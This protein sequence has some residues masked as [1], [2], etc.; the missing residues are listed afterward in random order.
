MQKRG[1]RQRGLF[2][3]RI[4]KCDCNPRLPAEHFRV[5]KEGKNK[6]RWFYTCQ[7]QEPKRC[8]FFLWDEDAKPREAAT[9]MS[10]STSEVQQNRHHDQDGWNAGRQAV[11]GNGVFSN[12]NAKRER[13]GHRSPTLSPYDTLQSGSKRSLASTG[14]DNSDD[15][16]G[17]N[18]DDDA[19]LR[20]ADS[21]ETPHKAQKIGVYATPATGKKSARKLPWL[22]Q[23]ATPSSTIKST[24]GYPATPSNSS[25]SR[26][27]GGNA[28]TTNTISGPPD[29]PTPHARFIDALAN[30]A[31]CASSLTQEVL[32][33][34]S[35]VSLP[36]EKLSTL[37]TILSRHDLKAQ[38]VAKGREIS[39][40]ALKAKEAKIVEL[41]SKIVRLE[42]E[43]EVDRG[44]IQKLRWDRQHIQ[45][46]DDETEDETDEIL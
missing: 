24:G 20:V 3:E 25:A 36:P 28:S 8:G 39:R 41:Q 43:L 14:F 1:G 33:H 35:G 2:E 23:P 16:W 11:S 10:N 15:N 17:L 34:L 7:Q 4:W 9:V 21:F 44:V 37:R 27:L 40:L 13:D 22:E 5:K 19:F 46:D 18:D 31:D 30:P 29:S 26:L 42:A 45:H 32:A 6:G 12:S 38:G